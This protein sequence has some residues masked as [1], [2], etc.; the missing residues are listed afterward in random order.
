M[1]SRINAYP[2][3][4]ALLVFALLAT[5]CEESEDPISPTVD[6]NEPI[7]YSFERNGQSTVSFS[8][9]TTRI[10]M[11]TE[12]VAGLKDFKTTEAT[13]LEMYRNET[14]SMEDANPFNDPDLNVATKSIKSKVA[15][16]KDFYSANTVDGLAI[17]ND[18]EAWISGQVNEVYPNENVAA[19]PGIPGQ[20]ADG[21]SVRYVN[22]Q[23]LEYDQMVGKGLIGALM[24]DQ[25]L[26][27]YLGIAVLDEAS[28]ISDNDAEIVADGK[29]YTTME[30][31]WDEA[32]GYLY[33]N[34]S[35][36][37]NPNATIGNDDS[38]LNKYVGRVEGDPDF[39]GI[40]DDIF[41]AFKRGRAAIV[42]QAYDIRDDQANI[43]RDKIST[44]IGVRAVYYLQQAKFLLEQPNPEMG[45]I[46]HDLSE[47][48]GFIYSLPFTRKRDAVDPY[49]TKAEVDEMI[50]D[51]LGD[52]PHGLW[53]LTPT[54]L[55]SIS[56]TI[57]DR[58]DFTIEQAGS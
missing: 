40:A 53:D 49:F 56:E 33:G 55:Q 12:L 29:P 27:H 48:Y 18:F 35:D 46:F 9:Q 20:I 8:G 15:A 21:T 44:V 28:N 16:S 57:A 38:F 14:A 19:E 10:K 34:T 5:S 52:G 58:F 47:A 2:N 30:H 37:T 32:Y 25:M 4:L 50:K 45:S 39:A 31:K 43:I 51:L 3:I 42:A 6:L 24:T 11:A 23:G 26:N 54:T 22:G 1:I 36:A 41:N 13:L 7:T 17:K